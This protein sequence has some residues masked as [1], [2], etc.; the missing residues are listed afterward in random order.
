MR[1]AILCWEVCKCTVLHG[2]CYDAWWTPSDRLA[3]ND[4]G[5]V[6]TPVPSPLEI[7]MVFFFASMFASWHLKK[8]LARCLL[9][10]CCTSMGGYISRDGPLIVF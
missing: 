2:G 10:E 8:A 5:F 4:P 3:P 9:G 1:V 7:L 6:L